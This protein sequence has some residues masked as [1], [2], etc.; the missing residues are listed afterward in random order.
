MF[1]QLGRRY[2][3]WAE[4]D[5]ERQLVFAAAVRD[6]KHFMSVSTGFLEGGALR[7]IFV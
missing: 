5:A 7:I 3:S 4:D 1:R 2:Q 6:P